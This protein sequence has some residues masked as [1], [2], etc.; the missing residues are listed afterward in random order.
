MSNTERMRIAI[1]SFSLPKINKKR[2]GVDIAIHR[3]GNA[4]AESGADVTI[5]SPCQIPPDA[6]YKY[7][8]IFPWLENTS[9]NKLVNKFA[10]LALFPFMLNFLDT[11]HFDVIHLNGDDWFYFFRRIPTIRVMHGSALREFQ[12]AKSIKRKILQLMLFPMEILSTILATVT[13]GGGADAAHIYRTSNIV[14]YG[15]DNRVFYPRIKFEKPT[16]FYVGTWQGR[17]RGEF[18][19]NLFTTEVLQACPDATLIM[20]CDSVPKH[21]NVLDLKHPSDMVLAEN[22]A[23]SWIFAY[24]ST[25]EGFG[26]PYVEALASGTVIVTSRNPGSE[27]IL[28]GNDCGI[29]CD[30]DIFGKE[31]VS[32]LLNKGRRELIQKKEIDISRQYSWSIIAEHFL[33]IYQDA[34]KK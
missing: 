15:V 27:F 34:I 5:L 29:V 26:I 4:L 3:L 17:K 28:T 2:A 9:G 30:D 32:L 24:P 7:L 20:L 19:F 8:Q 33:A 12:S 23:K 13:V 10:R 18:I 21:S 25:Y 6:L 14:N 31:L 16:I 1:I 11:T 22:L